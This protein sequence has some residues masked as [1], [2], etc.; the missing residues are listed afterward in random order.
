MGDSN[1]EDARLREIAL[2]ACRGGVGRDWAGGSLLGVRRTL[3]QF[4]SNFGNSTQVRNRL[5][6]HTDETAPSEW[7]G[8]HYEED[9][10][11]L[12][13]GRL[14][15]TAFRGQDHFGTNPY[16]GCTGRQYRRGFQS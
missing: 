3:A 9:E 2:F 16:R 6:E 4:E 1:P 10:Y 15:D 7:G 8:D 5:G 14:T 13:P 12:K 11:L